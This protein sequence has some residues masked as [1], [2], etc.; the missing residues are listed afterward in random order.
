MN[1]TLE[2]IIQASLLIGVLVF[3][4]STVS[5]I[6]VVYTVTPFSF[7]GAAVD[8]EVNLG[9][10]SVILALASISLFIW[11]VTRKKKAT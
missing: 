2:I 1:R 6:T 3:T 9:L 7:F 4:I 8:V 10:V 5:L 11:R